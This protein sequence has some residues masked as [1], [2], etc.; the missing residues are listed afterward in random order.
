MHSYESEYEKLFEKHAAVHFTTAEII[1]IHN[2][3]KLEKL[4]EDERRMG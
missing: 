4:R 3:F 2:G 1:S